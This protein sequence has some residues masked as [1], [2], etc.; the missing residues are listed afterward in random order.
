MSHP[1]P[2]AG[3][4]YLNQKPTPINRFVVKEHSKTA[5]W[6]AVLALRVS[7]KAAH[8]TEPGKR[9]NTFDEKQAIFFCRAA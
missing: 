8:Y 1:N 5:V 4:A 3:S 9:V 7:S 6:R 2:S